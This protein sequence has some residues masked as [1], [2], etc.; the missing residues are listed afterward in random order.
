MR[1]VWRVAASLLGAVLLL[2]PLDASASPPP[3]HLVVESCDSL[4]EASIRRIFAA[5][6]GTAATGD[7]GPDVTDVSI[8]CEGDRVVV[9]V[10]DPLSRKTLR[11][12]FDPRSF[13]NQGQS[14][15][16]AIA[17]SELVLASWAELAS[18]PTPKVLGEGQPA[19]AETLETARNVVKARSASSLA[20]GAKAAEPAAES[21]PAENASDSGPQRQRASRQDTGEG[22]PPFERVTAVVSI[23]SFFR[24]DGTLVGGGARLG[25]ERY[26]VVSWAADA[27]V[28]NGTLASHNVTSASL[29]GWL[30]FYAHTRAV[31]FRF[32]GGLRAGVLG[33]GGPPTVAAWGWPMVVS[34]LTLRFGPVVADVGGEAGLVD[35]LVRRNQGVKG[36]WA[37]G[38]FG[39]GLVL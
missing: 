21:E 2:W 9:R 38:Q 13:G 30:A 6:L 12:S 1:G 11:R 27:L 37:S 5:D 32:G 34:S 22:L 35:L 25:Q 16:I 20:V 36:P 19:K 24:G 17:A 31:T 39:L 18:N 28:E 8:G 3:V 15:L 14:R 4:D 7:L 29:G 33:L 10:K 23:R 26:G